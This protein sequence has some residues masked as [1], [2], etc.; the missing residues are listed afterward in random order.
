MFAS[1]PV[2]NRRGDFFNNRLSKDPLLM[3]CSHEFRSLRYLEL[4]YNILNLDWLM[5]D[6]YFDFQG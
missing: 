2:L 3:V 1:F 6:L 4:G 5:E